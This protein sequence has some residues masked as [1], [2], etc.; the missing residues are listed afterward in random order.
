MLLTQT[1]PNKQ[2]IPINKQL[3]SK[4]AA[5]YVIFPAYCKRHFLSSYFIN[6]NYHLVSLDRT[7]TGWCGKRFS[8]NSPDTYSNRIEIYLHVTRL[9][10]SSTR[11]ILGLTLDTRSQ[12]NSDN[13][14]EVLGLGSVRSLLFCPFW[15]YCQ[16]FLGFSKVFTIVV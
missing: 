8:S 10:R 4:T 6:I 12:T 11:I 13:L 15:T 16:E 5:L 14:C 9:N 2:S 7:C 1:H 3:C